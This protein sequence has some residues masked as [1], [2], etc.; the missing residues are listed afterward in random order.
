M[1]W[2][3]VTGRSDIVAKNG[4]AASSQ[5]LATQAGIEILIRGGNAVDAA[6]AIAAVLDVVEPFSTGCG[7][8][9]FALIHL[10]GR[11]SPISVNGSGRSGSL[12]SLDDLLEMGWTKM[13]LRGGA[14]VTVPGAMHMWHYVIDKYGSLELKDVLEPAIRYARTGFPV[15]DLISQVW[16][17]ATS[18]L[19]NDYAKSLYTIKGQSPQMGD[20]MKNPDLATVFESVATEGLQTFYSGKIAESIVNLVQ[21]YGGFLTLE[22]LETHKTEETTP[23]STKYRGMDVFEHP[24]NGQGF[25]ALIMLNLMEEFDIPMMPALST[26]RLH[27]MIESKK[28]A[29]GDLHQHNADMAFYEVPLKKLLSKSYAKERAI[30]IDLHHAMENYPSGVTLGSD[31][32]YLATADGEGRAVS[33]INSLYRGFGS[34]LVVPN[35]GIKLQNR[36]NLFSLDPKH[37]NCYAKKKLPFHTIIP[38]ALYRDGDIFGVF[39]IMGGAHQAQAHAQFVSNVVDYN[40]N[41]QAALDFPRFDHDHD[42]NLVALESGI[43]IDIQ[44]ELSKLGHRL[45]HETT[46]GFGGGQA[47]LRIKDSWIAGSDYRKD[48]QASGF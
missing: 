13:P 7:G 26:Q 22:D 18:I 6:V 21:E 10:P 1:Y 16:P 38:G 11:K 19:I 3:R 15:S 5:P 43:P 31:T 32:V 42:K 34:G 44:G 41:P 8:D 28:L 14:P 24:P 37:P 30:H 12:V 29:Y 2:R 4:V 27:L 23:I 47:I 40:M 48:G 20:I 33:L 25:A 46:S 35:T 36:G 9:A 39:G 45:V 17:M